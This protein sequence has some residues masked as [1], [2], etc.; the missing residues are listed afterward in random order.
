MSPAQLVT[1]DRAAW[2]S[3]PFVGMAFAARF[4]AHDFGYVLEMSRSEP[5]NENNATL[6]A[7]PWE[8]TADSARRR[9]LVPIFIL[10][11]TAVLLKAL[12][13]PN[14]RTGRRRR[15]GRSR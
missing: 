9:G 7:G 1:D 13:W 3:F 14:S 4:P 11:M 10:L 2:V 12:F 15:G 5:L 6:W 8:I